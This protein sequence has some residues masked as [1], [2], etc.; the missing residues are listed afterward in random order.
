MGRI[1]ITQLNGSD[2]L[3]LFDD[4]HELVSIK[5]IKSSMVDD[6]Y[7]ARIDQINEGLKAAFAQISPDKRVFLPLENFGKDI[8]KCGTQ[9]PVQIKTDPIKSKLPTAGTDI[10]IPGSLCVLHLEGTG[11]SVSRKLEASS[12]DFLF[13]EVTKRMTEQMQEFRWVIRTNAQN[14]IDDSMEP[15][16][17][18]MSSLM[19]IGLKIRESSSHLSLYSCLFSH[20]SDLLKCIFEIPFSEYDTI[21]T[22]NKLY[23][24]EIMESSLVGNNITIKYY[25]DQY[26]TLK[27]LH[28]LETYLNRALDSKVYLECGGYLIIEPTEAMTVI[29]VN[30][31]KAEGRRRDNDSY[32]F[33]INKE[34]AVEIARQLR[35][36]NISGIIIVDFISMKNKK[37][38]ENLIKILQDEFK[39]DRIL[40]QVVDIT[41][42]GLVEITRKKVSASLN[43]L[44]T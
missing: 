10:C 20:E 1:I 32:I 19:D 34:A 38:E 13:E 22:D 35:L 37:D 24:D 7:I 3:F 42:L 23:Y 27:N 9:L 15:L 8:P 28:S 31:G 41:P 6:I 30:S 2:F 11:V 14:L 25:D 36:R 39:K 40:T 26:I 4:E 29:D 16:F 5:C 44:I 43:Q 21:I 18:E 12:R 17:E 33:K